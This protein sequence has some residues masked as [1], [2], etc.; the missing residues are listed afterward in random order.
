LTADDGPRPPAP[1]TQVA[2]QIVRQP[3]RSTAKP[4]Q[5]ATGTCID[6]EFSG[7]ALTGIEFAAKNHIPATGTPVLDNRPIVILFHP[8]GSVSR[9]YYGNNNTSTVTLQDVEPAG[10]IYLLIGKSDQSTPLPPATLLAE[11]TNLQDANTY[12]LA[13]A[14]RTGAITVAENDAQLTL[15]GNVAAARSFA[16]TGQSMGGR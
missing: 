3:T 12:W 1:D 6:L 13:V 11:R 4:L 5:L 14:D 16:S 7:M 8:S 9:V 10:T 15:P 2:F